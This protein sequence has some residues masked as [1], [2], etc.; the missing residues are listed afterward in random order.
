MSNDHNTVGVTSAVGILYLSGAPRFDPVFSR[1]CDAQF[2]SFLCTICRPWFVLC[3]SICNIS[4]YPSVYH[5]LIFKLFKLKC[6]SI[7]LI[8]LTYKLP[9]SFLI[10]CK[11]NWRYLATMSTYD[12]LLGFIILAVPIFVDFVFH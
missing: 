9:S 10:S 2:Y 1:V 8:I 4:I 12:M 3:N 11:V 7:L 5:F 6:Q